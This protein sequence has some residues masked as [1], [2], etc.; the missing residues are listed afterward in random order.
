MKTHELIDLGSSFLRNN[1]ILSS[2][3]DSEIILSHIMGVSRERFLI[4]EQNVNLDR[5]KKFKSLILRRSKNEPIAYITKVKEFRSTN[6]F[7]DKN[8]LIPRPETELLIDP[9]ISIFRRRNLFFL[10]AGIGTGCIIFSILKELKHSRA[11]GIDKCKKTILNAKKNLIDL[12]LQNRAKLLHRTISDAFRYKFDLIVSNPPYVI[13]RDIRRLSDD[14]KRYEPRSALDGGND[15]LDVIRKVIYKSKH[16]LK[17]NGIL[18]LETGEGQHK[19][20]IKML[21]NNSFKLKETIKD[22][23]NNI[24]CIFSTLL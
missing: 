21:N 6:F 16:I 20:V 5:I 19:C 8:S 4:D 9:I 12:K 1:R 10:D 15:G 17:L 13:N 23:Q 3:I 2:R 22:Y 7:V 18:A 24:R 14:I 11:I